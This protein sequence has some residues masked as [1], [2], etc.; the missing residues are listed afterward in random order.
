[1]AA[2]LPTPKIG[3]GFRFADFRPGCCGSRR[4]ELDH[5]VRGDGG[6]GWSVI[7]TSK[8]RCELERAVETG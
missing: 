3:T 8:P 2:A 4:A 7:E 5:I 1:L 6:Y